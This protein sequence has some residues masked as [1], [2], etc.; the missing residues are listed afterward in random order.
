[1]RSGE[2]IFYETKHLNVDE[3]ASMFRDCMKA[4][5]DWH[6][7]TLNCSISL[8][9][10][11]LNCS[12]EE[13]LNSLKAN[14]HVVVIDRGTWGGPPGEDREHFEI[15]FRTMDS[16]VDYFLFIQVDSD[17][18]PP[19]LLKYQLIPRIYGKSN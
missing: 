10:H 7:D 2:F 4:S 13:I 12:F 6:A 18:M 11:C 8:A 15:G 16:P 1:M 19:I 5:Y 14:T 3:K 17:K 9:R